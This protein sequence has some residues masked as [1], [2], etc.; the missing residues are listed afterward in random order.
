MFS[1]SNG[2][3]G[4]VFLALIS[5]CFS[6]GLTPTTGCAADNAFRFDTRVL[7]PNVGNVCYAVTSADVDGD[8]K[9]DVI[10]V[11]ENRV[12]W[13]QNPDWKLRVIIENQTERD[14]VCIAPM[15]IDGD[16]KVDFALGAGWTKIGTLQWLTRGATLD[17][18]WQ[19]H[20]INKELGLH[21]VRA[22]DILGTGKPQ[23][24]ISP[25]NKSVAPQGV[26]LLAFE[27]PKQPKTDIWKATS[28]DETLNAMHAHWMG[29]FNADGKTDVIT[30]SMEGVYLFQG[31]GDGK[32][33]KIQLAAGEPGTPKAQVT[34]AGEVKVGRWRKQR[35]I[36]T[37]EPMHGHSVVIYTEPAAGQTLWTRHVLDKT[38]K[39]GHAIGLADFNGD[40]RDEVVLGHS[41]VGTGDPTGPGVFIYASTDASGETWTKSIVDQGGI[42]TEDLVVEDFNGDGLPDIAAGGRATHNVK[43]YL[44]RAKE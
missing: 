25:L 43:L 36:A 30:G 13:F 28:L 4:S 40:G 37:V 9:L 15:D 24:V 8:G 27:I 18:K 14:N 31:Q 12:V 19:V 20:F 41:D 42:A 29:D 1:R 22:G 23:I 44:G 3:A 10:A 5:A 2:F 11:T 7:D 34:G 16:G 38:L 6:L 26:R 17:D 35:L 32:T 39:R 21:R 33:E